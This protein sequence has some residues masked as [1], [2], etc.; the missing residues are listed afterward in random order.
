MV[1]H[2]V[3]SS[4]KIYNIGHKSLALF[5]FQHFW[6]SPPKVHIE[7]GSRRIGNFTITWWYPQRKCF[8]EEFLALHHTLET[9]FSAKCSVLGFIYTAAKAKFTISRFR[10]AY[11]HCSDFLA[12]RI[13]CLHCLHV[14]N[15]ALESKMCYCFDVRVDPGV[16]MSTSLR[17]F[18]VLR[19]LFCIIGAKFII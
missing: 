17:H 13:P 19:T 16:T 18:C 12:K 4:V 11:L 9:F 7:S 10:T 1:A 8:K 15:K 2:V 5:S 3:N 14:L 6:I